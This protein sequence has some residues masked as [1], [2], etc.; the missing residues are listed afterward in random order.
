MN[1]STMRIIAPMR[2]SMMILSLLLL[3]GCIKGDADLRKWV[4]DEKNMPGGPLPPL[5]V[6]KTFETYEYQAQGLRDPFSPSLAEQKA[7]EAE[8]ATL[9][10]PHPKEKLENFALD[11]LKMV[12]TIGVGPGMFGLIRDP[13]GTVSRVKVGDY[14]GQNNGKIKA[15]N[16][17][18]IDLVELIGNGNGGWLERSTSIEIGSK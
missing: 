4:A 10:D 15:I 5:P 12:G 6:L 17:G 7:E 3:G 16:E 13:E 2:W 1:V 14:L 9:P 18:G 8:K 11:S